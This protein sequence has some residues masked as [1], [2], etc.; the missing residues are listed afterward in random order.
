MRSNDST[1]AA[2]PIQRGIATRNGARELIADAAAGSR[3]PDEPDWVARVDRELENVR[4]AVTWAVGVGETELA[5]ELLGGLPG[6]MLN[7]TLGDTA[8]PMGSS[9][10]PP[11]GRC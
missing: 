9:R 7:T 1:R 10:A 8:V 3:G 5:I 11:P 2:P 6:L 4:A